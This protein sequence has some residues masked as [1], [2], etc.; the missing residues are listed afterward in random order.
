[1]SDLTACK[2]R[3]ALVGG[4][5]VSA[6]CDPRFTRD[7]DLA[8]AVASD[9]EAEGLVAA[10][11]GRGYRMLA[12]VE[13]EEVRKLATVRLAPPAADVEDGVVVDLLFASSGIEPEIVAE[14]EPLE[15]LPGLVVPV[16]RV[17][18]LIAVKILAS[19]ARRPQDLIDARQLLA[20]AR[21]DEPSRARELLRLVEQRGYTR[22]KDL[23]RDL[24]A[25]LA[26]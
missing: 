15:V 22:G 13:H 24:D 4:L 18:H 17:P 9:A 19:E 7:L 6:R 16:A 21:G 3:F 2:A 23:Q 11:L 10:L 26:G 12:Q 14:A 5:A 25:L 8:V 1:V 20:V